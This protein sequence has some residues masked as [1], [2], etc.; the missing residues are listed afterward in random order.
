MR[1]PDQIIGPPSNPYMLRWYLIPKNR[2]F[3]VYLHHILLPDDDRALHDHPWWSL[4]IILKGWYL[5]TLPNGKTKKR[6]RWE[7]HSQ[8]RYLDS[9]PLGRH[10]HRRGMD[11]FMTGP[12][13]RSWGFHCPQGWIH[14]RE[15]V[16]PNNPGEIG[17][18][19]DRSR[20]YDHEMAK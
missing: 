7:F 3:N 16:H 10:T 15:F 19:C 17:R 12:K 6:S 13:I 14:H 5:E 4:S 18:G 2:F 11:T 8:E 20:G 1:S 9:L